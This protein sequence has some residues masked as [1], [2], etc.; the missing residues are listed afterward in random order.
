MIR[1]LSL[2]AL[3]LALA[4]TAWA[5]TP[6]TLTW[7]PNTEPSLT[8]YQIYQSPVAGQYAAPPVRV[9]PITSFSGV[10][11]QLSVD[12]RYYFTITAYNAAGESPR[13]NEVSKVAPA[14]AGLPPALSVAMPSGLAYPRV[15]STTIVL[16]FT[17]QVPTAV[18]I[19]GIAG[20]PATVAHWP[21]GTISSSYRLDATGHI[22]TFT[23]CL[24]CFP[25][26]GVYTLDLTADY[27]GGHSVSP[28]PLT[29]TLGTPNVTY[30]LT[31][32][33]SGTGTGSVT[34]SPAGPT[35]PAGASVVLTAVPTA[36]STF[37]GWTGACTG[38]TVCTV[39]MSGAKTV[40][41]LFPLA[42]PAP[43]SNLTISALDQNRVVIVANATAC[44]SLA[45]TGSGLKR[46]V[47]CLPK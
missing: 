43:P 25:A 9:G 24:S 30:A 13:S 38:L 47:T 1:R 11:P 31:V 10:L 45:T 6:F 2:L 35:F 27:A 3:L 37:G 14:L 21:T 15:G 7:L 18:S 46:T 12:T 34:T 16:T 20:V 8:G 22:L 36:G 23:L 4:G 26:D 28:A 40:G 32:S 17:S 41:A 5:D 44:K 42:V 29:L 19:A 33:T 39:T